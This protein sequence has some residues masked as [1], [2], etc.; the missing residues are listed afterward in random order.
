MYSLPVS[1]L[2]QALLEAGAFLVIAGVGLARRGEGPWAV[3]ATVGGLLASVVALVQ[4]AVY[5]EVNYLETSHVQNFIYLHEHVGPGLGWTRV[6]GFVL[7]AAGLVVR[8]RE[9][10]PA[11]ET[12]G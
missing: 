10:R 11:S 9:S 12:A 8:A 3:L 4:V 5:V 1:Y 2:I 7:V 6:A